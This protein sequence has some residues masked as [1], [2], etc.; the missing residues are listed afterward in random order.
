M[1]KVLILG[2]GVS[3]KAVAAFLEKR[4][5]SWTAVDRKPTD[6]KILS[7]AISPRFE[8]V[9]L[10]IKS[11]G[12]PPQHPWVCAAHKEKI[13]VI[14]EIDLAL[15]EVKG[16]RLLAITGSNG[17]T[18]T[19]LLT[20]H[21][22]GESARAVGNVGLPLISQI[23]SDAKTLVVELSSFQ[24]EEMVLKPLF[25]AAVILNITPNHLDRYP[26]F[27]AYAQAKLRLQHCLKF[28]A[29]LFVSHQVASD[30]KLNAEIFDFF[31]E[32]VET[33]LS[34]SYRDRELHWYPHDL[35]NL[36]AAYA[37]TQ[38]PDQM[39]CEKISTFRKPPH[40]IEF[41][42]KLGGVDY[43]N[44]SKA[45]S[46]DAVAKAVVALEQGVILIAGGVDK[47]GS[48]KELIPLFRNKVKRVFAIGGAANR[49]FQELH[50]EIEVEL[51]GSIDEGVKKASQMALAGDVVLLSPGCSSYDQFVDYQQRGEKFKQL[52]WNL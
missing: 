11:P 13:P 4:G 27:E 34:L 3:G 22:L 6:E 21:L 5:I 7:E 48:F 17:K 19:T 23:D 14:G 29:S 18:T 49:I 51:V 31:K 35:Q 33:I 45:T 38:L 36:C 15:Q 32:K 10:V 8:G 30:F 28:G 20:A 52:V 1:Q 40:R 39:Y 2:F 47:G 43:I 12:I 16:K 9:D 44:D 26:S 41:V 25:D 46:V 50:S 42:R 24:L 37:L